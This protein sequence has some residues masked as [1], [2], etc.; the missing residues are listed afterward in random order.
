MSKLFVKSHVARDLL[1]TAENFS[2]APK[3]IWEYVVNG[4]Q[5]VDKDCKPEVSVE[6]DP[7]KKQ[8]LIRDNGRGMSIEDLRNYFTMHGE[9]QDRVRG[10]PG[11]GRF[12]TGKSAAFGIGR[13]IQITTFKDGKKCAVELEKSD[14]EAQ[15]TGDEIPVKVMESDVVTSPK[16]KNGTIIQISEIFVRL[17]P[18]QVK[19]FIESQLHRY[20]RNVKVLVNSE[21]CE[22]P[23]PN[24]RTGDRFVFKPSKEA[25]LTLGEIEL[26]V[27]ITSQY[28]EDHQ[29]G[30]A[31]CSG[32]NM[33]ELR[34]LDGNRYVCG[35]V[36]IPRLEEDN[37][38]PSAFNA[39]RD[40]K[41]NPQNKLV[42][43]IYDFIDPHIREV[44]K[45]YKDRHDQK[46]RTERSK[47]LK[48]HANRIADFLNRD[49]KKI[50]EK[51]LERETSKREKVRE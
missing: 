29:K 16:E 20:S 50:K 45:I 6:I 39:S 38:E 27:S 44:L 7:F 48:K 43:A 23:S 25:A 15:S 8:V 24:V 35:E 18:L 28:L 40:L 47:K 33:Y 51:V 42:K 11:R 2:D 3:A 34:A 9:N 12:G 4:L 32:E 46:Q 5:Y 22:A 14:V 49:F 17:D 10:C 13:K 1:Q 26:V 30:V 31:I 37:S 36:N 41:L 21:L 19:Q